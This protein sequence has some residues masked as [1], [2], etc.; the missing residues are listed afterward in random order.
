MGRVLLPVGLLSLLLGTEEAVTCWCGLWGLSAAGFQ[1]RG[2]VPFS[3][4]SGWLK[5][6]ET[7]R[8]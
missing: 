4:P 3:Q 7:Q 1:G 5:C 2:Q 8:Q 6:S